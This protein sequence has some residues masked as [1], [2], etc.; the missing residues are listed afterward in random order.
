MIYANYHTH[1]ARCQH[2]SGEDK[3]YVE[4]AIQAGIQILGFSD[5]CPWIFPDDHVSGIRMSPS[6]VDDYVHSLETLRHDYRQDIHILIGFEAEYIPELM[7]AQDSFLSQYPIDYMLLGQHFLGN[8][9]TS[10]YMGSPTPDE[11]VLAA[12]VDTIIEGM[13]SGRYLYVAHPDLINYTGSETSYH[14]HMLRLCRYLKE[15][16]IPVELNALGALQERNYP[17]ERFMKI[18]KEAG[19]TC[20]IGVD[21]HCPEQLTDF[22]GIARCEQLAKK[23]DLHLSRECSL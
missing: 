12:Y 7:E 15:K 5:H 21:A 10:A 20:I 1:T 4:A 2:A 23:Y 22:S 16:D 18:A 3:A 8:E 11:K 19:N 9:S 6:Q 17:S 13:D 14:Q